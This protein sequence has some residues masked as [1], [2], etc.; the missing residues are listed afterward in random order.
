M[1]NS[2]WSSICLLLIAT[3]SAIAL[4]ANPPAI[5]N[6]LEYIS[7]SSSVG[8]NQITVAVDFHSPVRSDNSSDY[9]LYRILHDSI[10]VL[11]QIQA[12]FSYEMNANLP[13]HSTKVESRIANFHSLKQIYP[14]LISRDDQILLMY[15]TFDY[16]QRHDLLSKVKEVAKLAVSSGHDRDTHVPTVYVISDG[17][18]TQVMESLFNVDIAWILPL[19]TALTFLV[20]ALLIRPIT[21]ILSVFLFNAIVCAAAT[22]LYTTLG[23]PL[24]LF[25]STSFSL[26]VT[27]C[28]A[29]FLHSVALPQLKGKDNQPIHW[30]SFILS[31]LTSLLGFFVA[32]AFS[33]N[34]IAD[35]HLLGS[36]GAGVTFILGTIGVPLVARSFE[37]T[38]RRRLFGGVFHTKLQRAQQANWF[39][40][41]QLSIPILLVALTNLAYRDAP[42]QWLSSRTEQGVAL[43]RLSESTPYWHQLT[44][45]VQVDKEQLLESVESAVVP[46]T[47]YSALTDQRLYLE[48]IKKL[49]VNSCS[50]IETLSESMSRP[51]DSTSPK[52]QVQIAYSSALEDSN[53]K[54][55][56]TLVEIEGSSLTENGKVFAR[57]FGT[58]ILAQSSVAEQSDFIL[59]QANELSQLQVCMFCSDGKY[60]VFWR[61]SY[62]EQNA[63]IEKM[64]VIGEEMRQAA[65][66]LRHAVFDSAVDALIASSYVRRV[67]SKYYITAY[68]DLE[69]AQET[70][71]GNG[72]T[73]R[74]LQYTRE[75][76][77]DAVTFEG[78]PFRDLQ[79]SNTLR[80]NAY[81]IMAMVL[82]LLTFLTVSFRSILVGSAV[83]SVAIFPIAAFLLGALI[84]SGSAS[85]STLTGLVI[86]TGLLVDNAIY[87][88]NRLLARYSDSGEDIEHFYSASF[89][90]TV[91][92]IASL[93]PLLVSVFWVVAERSLVAILIA[94]ASLVICWVTMPSALLYSQ[95]IAEKRVIQKIVLI[96]GK[97]LFILAI[98]AIVLFVAFYFIVFALL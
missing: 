2:R 18:S 15:F 90:S 60:P 81:S 84:S 48:D 79:L 40:I 17:L 83:T 85:F 76:R 98:I 71:D 1:P 43:S 14:P 34:A 24:S 44:L 94:S 21:F 54:I 56:Q 41:I 49:G 61:M 25:S 13:S 33:K 47:R 58:D 3:I 46:S 95:T 23:L 63:L 5:N 6:S 66:R 8:N 35:A 74:V 57:S 39:W 65:I 82:V 92:L 97:W 42:S 20:F 38:Y 30:N 68:C 96:A 69:I 89:A 70:K 62:P 75:N 27:M 52:R 55:R 16:H 26:I 50:N 73:E 29:N 51:N 93:L 64:R 22:A 10:I 77:S 37:P 28:T 32:W 67:D 72:L 53:A 19:G 86:I 87:F 4:A 59:D 80:S 7:G 12:S 31:N 45:L 9:S 91:V 36:I 11:P 78:W 88:A